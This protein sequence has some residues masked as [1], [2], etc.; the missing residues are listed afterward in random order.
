MKGIKR[1]IMRAETLEVL[2]LLFAIIRC[3][4]PN[5]LSNSCVL[6]HLTV[7]VLTLAAAFDCAIDQVWNQMPAPPE[8]DDDAM[9]VDREQ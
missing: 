5:I 3:R 6:Q 7:S 4:L 8:K 2:C 1:A 9:R